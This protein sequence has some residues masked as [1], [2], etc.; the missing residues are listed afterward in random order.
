MSLSDLAAFGD[1]I[2]GIAVVVSFIFLAIQLRQSTQNQRASVALERAALTQSIGQTI[3]SGEIGDLFLRGNAADP[4]LTTAES[5][6]YISVALMTFWLYEEHFYLRRDGMLD[7][8]RWNTN[9]RR[10]RAMMANPGYR[11]AWR[12]CAPF[13]E[14]DFAASVEDAIRETPTVADV[15][16]F[17][18]GWKAL[19]AGEL[20]KATP[21]PV[22]ANLTS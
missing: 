22:S 19:A 5:S 10:L 11:A 2:G 18:N 7:D 12:A 8:A 20:A 9:L 4:T 16:M 1:F 14:A 6:R 17:A 15:T 13:F 3:F 21:A